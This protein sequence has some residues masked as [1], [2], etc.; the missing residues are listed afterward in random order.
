MKRF[1]L[2]L[3][4]LL[5]AAGAAWAQGANVDPGW[6]AFV[7]RN[8][9][10]SGSPPIIVDR[11]DLGAGAVEFQ[12]YEGGQKAALGTKP[13]QRRHRCAGRCPSY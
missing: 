8:A 5:L 12:I 2:C 9:T 11:L 7:I 13:D 3:L 4:A 6:D 1:Y 10:V